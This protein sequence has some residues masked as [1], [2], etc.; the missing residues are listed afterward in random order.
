MDKALYL[1]MTG[2]VHLDRAQRIHAHNLANVSTT[3]FRAD[4]AQAR[5]MQVFGDG[6]PSRVYALTEN[7]A[8]DFSVGSLDTTGRGLDVA[9]DGAGFFA[10]QTA[11]GS[12][13]YTRAGAFEVNVEGILQTAEGLPVLGDSGPMLLPPFETVVIGADGTVSIRPVGQAESN[14]VQVGALKRVNPEPGALSKRVDGLFELRGGGVADADNE[15][16]VV[17]GVLEASNVNAV[18]EMVD[19]LTLARQ[20]ELHV[21]MMQTNEQNNQ[22][23]ARLLQ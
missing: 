6:Q 9:I 17:S 20:F 10:V 16:R 1:A 18:A 21:K 12:E 7:P 23:A 14:L 19:I 2:A 11:D 5:A 13:A 22:A 15:V 4:L 3:G 8:T